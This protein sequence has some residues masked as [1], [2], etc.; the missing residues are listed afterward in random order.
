[1]YHYQLQ[2]VN[3][4]TWVVVTA[5]TYLLKPT[6]HNMMYRYIAMATWIKA[7]MWFKLVFSVLFWPHLASSAEYNIAVSLKN[8]FSDI[9]LH[10]SGQYSPCNSVC[11]HM[12]MCVCE[13]YVC[14]GVCV[15]ACVW[16]CCMHVRAC[17]LSIVKAW[18]GLTAAKIVR[19]V[20]LHTAPEVM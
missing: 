2:L 8:V 18:I 11:V 15:H 10:N 16:A 9:L 4:W 3:I 13:A 12:C 5:H 1:M 17:M 14:L 19:A 7:Y 6:H 20:C